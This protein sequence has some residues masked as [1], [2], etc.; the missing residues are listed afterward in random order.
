[1]TLDSQDGAPRRAIAILSACYRLSAHAPAQ[2]AGAQRLRALA[3]SARSAY[4]RFLPFFARTWA[5]Q[6]RQLRV[7]GGLCRRELVDRIVFHCL[8]ADQL[9][10]NIRITAGR[11]A[12]STFVKNSGFWRGAVPPWNSPSH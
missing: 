10:R 4:G 6:E 8:A 9:R 2:R 11:Q 7:E 3:H 1:M 5:G 12:L